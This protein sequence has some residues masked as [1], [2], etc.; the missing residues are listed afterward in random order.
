[1]TNAVLDAVKL[2]TTAPTELVPQQKPQYHTLLSAN[3]E[4]A[5]QAGIEISVHHSDIRPTHWGYYYFI[6]LLLCYYYS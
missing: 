6:I 2:S 5:E 4:H 3:L 1:M